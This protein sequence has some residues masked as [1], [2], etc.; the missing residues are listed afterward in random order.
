MN[1]NLLWLIPSFFIVAFLYGSVGHG[2]A[3]GYLAILSLFSVAP[4]LM[5]TSALILNCL[6]SG[7]AFIAFFRAGYFSHRLTWP[8]VVASIPAAFLGGMLHVS[9]PLYQFL[10][11]VTLLFAAFRLSLR[12]TRKT[13]S[14]LRHPVPL[15]TAF[16]L[17][18]GIGFLSGMVGVGGGIFLSPLLL[19]RGWGDPKVV[20][21][22][23]SC[24]ILANSI[25]G[26]FG[27]VLGGAFGI[28]NL[29]PFIVSALLGGWIGSHLGANHFSGITLCRLLAVVLV[30]AAMKLIIL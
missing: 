6:V 16:P 28:G 26:L 29:F 20:S 22:T 5:G 10:L 21:A 23:S 15:V 30:I 24:F 27:R 11:A 7:T 13:S 17:G 8:F 14:A 2:G 18:G 3:S 4:T 9:A 12:P 25:A 19:L 1:E